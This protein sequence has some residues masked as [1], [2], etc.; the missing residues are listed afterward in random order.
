[1]I[2]R[3]FSAMFCLLAMLSMAGCAHFKESQPRGADVAPRVEQQQKE[4]VEDYEGRRA[5]AEMEAARSRAEHGDLSG[6]FTT[7]E[8]LLARNPTH[9]EARLMMADV[10]LARE[11]VRA[12]EQLLKS[13]VQDYPYDAAS[14]HALALLLEST[15]RSELART[16]FERAAA[17]DPDDPLFALSAFQ[18][19]GAARKAATIALTAA[20]V[21]LA[22]SPTPE[23]AAARAVI[24]AAQSPE[25]QAAIREALILLEKGEEDGALSAM[26]LAC[27]QE[28]L[29]TALPLAASVFLL[30]SEKADAAIVLLEAAAERQ[31]KASTILR[32]LGAAYLQ[33]GDFQAAQVVLQQA[34]SLDSSDALA[35]F[36]VGQ[37][38]QLQGR[39]ADARAMMRAA[40][41]LDPRFGQQR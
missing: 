1:M 12:A 15:G 35:Y 22:T 6:C 36:L 29:N 16:H 21:A 32:G 20:N 7:L 31:P 34:I 11:N 26:Q 19:E 33:A 9:R 10:Q 17:I 3:A 14:H 5:A 24:A 18:N 4:I 40:V 28:S 41:Q 37:A 27:E 2:Q 39:H 25:G 23:A 30:R 8:A 13:L 38:L